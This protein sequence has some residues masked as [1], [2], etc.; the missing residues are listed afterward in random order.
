MSFKPEE[1]NKTVIN[2]PPNNTK[3]TIMGCGLLFVIGA[4]LIVIVTFAGFQFLK[5]RISMQPE[6]ALDIARQIMDYD[7]PGGAIGVASLELN[8]KMAVVQGVAESPKIT[9]MLAATPIAS[10]SEFKH[11][12]ERHA[13]AIAKDKNIV[14]DK[15]EIVEENICG[16]K[17]QVSTQQN[18]I[19]S[20]D[21]TVP[22]TVM[23]FNLNHKEKTLFV[24]IMSEGPGNY[25]TALHILKSLTCK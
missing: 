19:Q 2:N 3:K 23:Q 14:V 15:T 12:L 24:M 17:V 16:K 21:K 1:G 20:K 4:I 18:H 11:V 8:G 6:K 5:S 10:S 7:I 9:L 25:E 22:L 13:R